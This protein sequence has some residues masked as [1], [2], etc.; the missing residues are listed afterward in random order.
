M[1]TF[2]FNLA[3][4]PF[5]SINDGRGRRWIS[6]SELLTLKAPARFDH[7][8]AALNTPLMMLVIALT[9]HQQDALG[10][11]KAE[12]IQA[13][14]KKGA[15]FSYKGLD[16]PRTEGLSLFGDAA[17]MQIP[18]QWANAVGVAPRKTEGLLKPFRADGGKGLRIFANR[19][20]AICPACAALSLF[21]KNSFTTPMAQYWARSA[22]AGVLV[23]LH[24][25]VSGRAYDLPLSIAL[26]LKSES[27]FEPYPWHAGA[28][29]LIDAI[30]APADEKLTDSAS[31][32]PLIRAQRLIA[33]ET[34]GTC[35]CCGRADQPIVTKYYEVG[36]KTLFSALDDADRERV[37]S[38][39]VAAGEASGADDGG[40]DEGDGGGKKG[41]GYSG[42]KLLGMMYADFESRIHPNVPYTIS[43]DK[44]R[45]PVVHSEGIGDATRQYPSWTRF[46]EILAENSM[47][48]KFN[49]M[50]TRPSM[51]ALKAA[52]EVRI[53]QQLFTIVPE[54]GTNPTPKYI[55]DDTYSLLYASD[56]VRSAQDIGIIVGAITTAT[57]ELIDAIV[58]AI[59]C[60]FKEVD[61][62]LDNISLR[63]R[64][65]NGL[66]PI[67]SAKRLASVHTAAAELWDTAFLL[68]NMAAE[69]IHRDGATTPTITSN[70]IS[71]LE[72]RAKSLW[73]QVEKT[74]FSSL[75]DARELYLQARASKEFH[76]QIAA[77]HKHA[78]NSP[79]QTVKA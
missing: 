6:L 60:L 1:D 28:S 59:A 30:C 34:T 49:F 25:A 66:N 63:S 35:A 50:S 29:S 2:L 7:P 18:E 11:V 5:I 75:A 27:R 4:D 39:V 20:D 40:V 16:A 79:T 65:A 13:A 32:L 57:R 42:A 12:D 31:L 58:S 55:A 3:V 19:I 37:K 9:Q 33:P 64:S 48:T 45:V 71:A 47:K 36:E 24:Q 17:F 23:V 72:A 22:V 54:S 41:G 53:A 15:G 69:E 74:E 62:G 46:H 44:R 43:K 21:F 52:A 51:K 67:G 76:K 38:A 56:T 68:V 61:I 8:V 26:N 78:A 77:R 14:L 10:G 70:S 73:K